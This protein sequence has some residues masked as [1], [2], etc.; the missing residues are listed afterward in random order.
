MRKKI[1]LLLLPCL[2]ASVEVEILPLDVVSYEQFSQSDPET[3]GTVVKALY[4]KGIVGIRGVPGY[5]E[6]VKNFVESSRAFASLPDSVKDACAPNH[7]LGEMFLGYEKGKEKFLRPDGKWVIDNLKVSYYAYVP[8][9]RQ[10]KWPRET[11]LRTAFQD[12]GML[13]ADTAE[14]VMEKIDLVGESNGIYVTDIPKVG[15]MI[16]YQ[17]C[18][19]INSGNPLWCGSHYDHG[20]FTALTPATYFVEGEEVSEPE[21]R[22]LPRSSGM[23]WPFFSMCRWIRRSTPC[24]N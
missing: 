13:L 11:D 21:S 17:K 2:L 15:R 18:G 23:R 7:D 6:K 19:N 16:Y 10:N 1:W 22:A 8:E 14:R 12:L 5:V 9:N 20:L 4:E 3:V 24:R